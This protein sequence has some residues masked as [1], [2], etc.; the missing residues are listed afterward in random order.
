MSYAPTHLVLDV[1][2]SGS[3]AYAPADTT[4]DGWL[5]GLSSGESLNRALRP[6]GITTHTVPLPKLYEGWEYPPPYLFV[7]GGWSGAPT[8]T[9]ADTVRDARWAPPSSDSTVYPATVGEATEFGSPAFVY[10]QSVGVFGFYGGQVGEHFVEEAFLRDAS[11]VGSSTFHPEHILL[12]GWWAGIP[13]GTHFALG[14]G[15]TRV[16]KPSV[17]NLSLIHI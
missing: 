14:W 2:W 13:P 9:P 8:Y 17:R 10:N 5:G 16:G 3:T 4:R 11:W 6:A 1:T 12:Y 15:S 7:N